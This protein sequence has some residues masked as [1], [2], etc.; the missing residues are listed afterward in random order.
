[1]SVR[2]NDAAANITAASGDAITRLN[3]FAAEVFRT[4]GGRIGSG[5]GLLFE[6]LWGYHVNAVL[7]EAGVPIE[8]A[9][10]GEHQYNDFAVVRVGEA[11]DPEVR[12]GELLRIEAKSMI[13]AADE[14]KAH[15]DAI[16]SEIGPSDLLLILVWDW[17]DTGDGLST[18]QIGDSFLGSALSLAALRD[19][20]HVARGGSFVLPG[21]CPDGCGAGCGHIGE[22]LNASGKRE[23]LSGPESCRVSRKTSHAANFGGLSRMIGTSGRGATHVL[24][25]I[26]AADPVARDY[27]EFIRRSVR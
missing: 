11:W 18:P 25:Q 21:A 9:W 7:R 16:Q 17:R 10:L 6:A 24:E 12:R 5:M 4:R 23:R 19:G 2:S 3:T 8:V 1:M 14:S 22:P 13:S 26:C 15:F 27:V 20:L